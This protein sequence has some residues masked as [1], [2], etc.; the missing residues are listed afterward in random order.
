MVFA[1]ELA[2][3]LLL[4]L[5]CCWKLGLR[6]APRWRGAEGFLPIGLQYHL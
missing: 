4:G 2:L 1:Q 3:L 6:Y 5:P